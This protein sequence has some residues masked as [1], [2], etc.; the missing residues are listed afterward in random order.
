[1]RV[2]N[3]SDQT[4]MSIWHFDIMKWG[5]LWHC[6]A[7]CHLC[8]KTDSKEKKMGHICISDIKCTISQSVISQTAVILCY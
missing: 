2:L 7:W 5:S 8:W 6:A 1:M 4:K 3:A